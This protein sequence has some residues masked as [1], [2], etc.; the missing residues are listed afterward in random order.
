MS[1]RSLLIIVSCGEMCRILLRPYPKSGIIHDM[2]IRSC[3]SGLLLLACLACTPV[4]AEATTTPSATTS[5]APLESPSPTADLTLLAANQGVFS[6]ILIKRQPLWVEV[7]LTSEQQR[8][9]LMNRKS[10]P[11]HQGMIFVFTPTRIVTFWMKDTLIPLSIAF[12]DE[13]NKIIDIQDME[14]KSEAYH[15][16]PSKV[17]YAIEANQGWFRKYKIEIGAQIIIDKN[18]KLLAPKF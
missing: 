5:S 12:V 18:D 4:T 16:S 7:A 11:D 17:K 1:G 9:G 3:F 6:K 10:M 8:Q 13:N 2:F 15:V 14:P